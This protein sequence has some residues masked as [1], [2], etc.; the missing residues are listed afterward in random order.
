[1]MAAFLLR[2]LAIIIYVAFSLITPRNKDLHS[3]SSKTR[4]QPPIQEISLKHPEQQEDTTD[5]SSTNEAPAPV[6]PPE[7]QDHDYVSERQTTEEQLNAAQSKIVELE[8]MIAKLKI[9]RFGIA[10]FTASD[11]QI[12][13]FTGF[14][15]YALLEGFFRACQP[16]ALKMIR[17]S[18]FLRQQ[19]GETSSMRIS[20]KHNENLPLFD[21][22][23]LFLHKLRLGNKDDELA[24]KF[25]VGPSTVSRITI[26][27]A[28]YLYFVLGSIPVWP[29]RAKVDA[30]MPAVF[31][32]TYPKTRVILDCTEIKTQRPSS[33]YL[34]SELYSHYKSSQTFK[35]L[36]G[37]VP[38][39][40]VSF[41]SSLYPGSISDKEI[42]KQSNILRLIEPG[43]EVM[44]DKG[45]LIEDLLMTKGASL[46]IPPFLSMKSQLEKEE[47][48]TTQVIARL[49]IHVERAIRRIKV[50][51]IFS[52]VVPLS[53]AGTINQMWT[54]CCLL[55]NFQGPL[56]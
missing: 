21:Q 10:R 46:V 55:T 47:V 24:E 33:L 40:A 38:T 54:V 8:E 41:V 19:R 31:K 26:T 4:L 50:Y 7:G 49:R 30:R 12:K 18:Q 28:N 56:F 43:D 45:F 6:A 52:G 27:W 5:L 1:M 25:D 44:T 36:I 22:L 15:S 16:T 34:N 14:P 29:S 9:S 42:T 11:V 23:F 37:I 3:L 53:L 39:G 48:A 51:H 32:A 2:A 35:G 13:F 17:W 20:E